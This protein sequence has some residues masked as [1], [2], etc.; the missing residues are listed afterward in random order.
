MFGV[1]T[2]FV[3]SAYGA[4]FLSLS[5]LGL[6]ALL[7]IKKAASERKKLENEVAYLKLE[8]EQNNQDT[9]TLVDAEDDFYRE[10]S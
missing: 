9:A 6:Y 1:H 8:L 4:A 3:F 5:V 7:G 2:F 10:A